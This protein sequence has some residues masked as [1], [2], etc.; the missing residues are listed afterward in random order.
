MKLGILFAG[1]GSQTVGMGKDLYEQYEGFKAVFDLLP[2][3]QRQ[4]AFEGPMEALSDTRNTQP[5]MV[6][7]AAGIMAEL[8]KAGIEPQMAAGLSLGEYSALHS[9][10]VFDA[11]TAIKLVT[12]RALEMHEAAEGVDCKMSAVLNFDREAL[13]SCCQDASDEGIV[14]IANYNCPGQIVIA[15]EGA[16]VDKAVALATERGAK[17][18]IPLPVSGPFHTVFMEPAGR[19][20]E[21]VFGDIDFA[22]MRFPVVF[23]AIGREKA[24]T[25]TIAE[26]L[27]KQ[28]S[29]SVYF[30]DTIKVMQQA[31]IDTIIEVGPGKALAGFVRKTCKDIKVLG[32]ETAADLEKVM[33]LLKGEA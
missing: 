23:N 28:V 13:A 1:Q 5:I 27:V 4:I 31:G 29:N 2:K 32:I 15:G 22:D 21:T 8:S 26:L 3:H 17:R 14:Q 12:R 18:C 19:A 9:A 25:Q 11:E 10:G 33:E 24:E 30:E 20:L 7:F 6:A 16:A